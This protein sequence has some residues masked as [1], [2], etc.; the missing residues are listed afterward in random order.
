[1]G[2]K[3]AR[4][5]TVRQPGEEEI[6]RKTIHLLHAGDVQGSSL[7]TTDGTREVRE[8]GD[9]STGRAGWV[10]VLQHTVESCCGF[11]RTEVEL[12]FLQDK[13]PRL[14]SCGPELR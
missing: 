11:G 8:Q 4:M 7:V 14:L 1:M 2:L 6:M 5:R 13:D 10:L 3:R 9:W 12:P